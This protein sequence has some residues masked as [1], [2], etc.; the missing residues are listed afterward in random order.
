[1]VR[2]SLTAVLSSENLSDGQQSLRAQ[3]RCW[4]FQ[5]ACVLRFHFL[6]YL[7]FPG[8]VFLS[9]WVIKIGD[10]FKIYLKFC[11]IIIRFLL[12]YFFS[13][14]RFPLWA[15]QRH[16]LIVQCFLCGA[17]RP[18][19]TPTSPATRPGHDEGREN[20]CLHARSLCYLSG[21]FWSGPWHVGLQR[22][23]TC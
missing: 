13:S 20:P 10:V 1:M 12:T 19:S 3:L 14:L 7:S 16:S 22:P 5:K 18:V 21:A 17:W 23:A 2:K 6:L 9:F 15:S 4:D 11:R 8:N